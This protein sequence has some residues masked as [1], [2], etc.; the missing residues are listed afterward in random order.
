METLQDD[1][2]LEEQGILARRVQIEFVRFLMR[3]SVTVAAARSGLEMWRTPPNWSFVN[4]AFISRNPLGDDDPAVDIILDF[5]ARNNCPSYMLWLDDRTDHAAWGEILTARGFEYDSGSPCMTLDTRTL[6]AAPSLPHGLRIERVGNVAGLEYFAQVL[7]AG[8]ELNEQQTNG[9][10]EL[11]GGFGIGGPLE[12]YIGFIGNEAV[13]SAASD[14]ALGAVGVEFVSTLPAHRGK[15][16]GSAITQH[17]AFESRRR[18]YRYVS[19]SASDMGIPVYKRLGFVAS[20]I[21]DNYQPSAT[22]H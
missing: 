6:P 2:T 17:I 7:S 11:W 21:A 14:K 20:G 16:L 8:F 1:L 9:M 4:G 13:T 19:L 18:G 5:F 15:G 12:C 10:F 3:S 22:G